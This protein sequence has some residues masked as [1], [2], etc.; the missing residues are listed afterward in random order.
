MCNERLV[1]VYCVR[2]E[3]FNVNNLG[4]DFSFILA[5]NFSVNL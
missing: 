2:V 1:D 3:D 5:R 4:D